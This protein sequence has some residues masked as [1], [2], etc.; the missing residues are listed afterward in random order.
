MRLSTVSAFAAALF[1]A[2]A[3]LAAA[4][5]L[6]GKWRIVR[7][8]G[9]EGFDTARTRAEFAANG[10]FASTVG[11]NRIAGKPE[12]SGDRIAFGQMMA[13]RMACPGALGETERAYLEAL[14]DVRAWR[15]EGGTLTFLGEDGAALVALER[16]E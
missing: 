9:A 3:A 15:I 6:S 7:I 8:A 11:C 2:C 1:L 4:P 13:P 5:G 10:R 12:V 16:A 14:R